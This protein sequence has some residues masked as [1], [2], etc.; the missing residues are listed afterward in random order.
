MTAQYVLSNQQVFDTNGDPLAGAKL[1]FFESGTTTPL[2]TYSESTL[3][4]PNAH[5]VVADSS[6]RFGPIYLAVDEYKVRLDTSADVVIF[7]NDP[8]S[9]LQ[10]FSAGAGLEAHSSGVRVRQLI[11][12]QTGTTYT[13]ANGDRAKLVTHS[14]SSAIAAT[15]P[16]AGVAS[17]FETGWF[18]DVK[19]IGVGAVTIT[20]TTSTID[21]ASS[22]VLGTGSTVRI[23]SDGTNYLTTSGL[24]APV[25]SIIPFSGR[26]APSA[27]LLCYGQAISRTAYASLFAV[28]CPSLGTFTVTIASPAVFT[29]VAH[30]L[31]V[32]ELIRFTTTGALP[33]GLS[34]NTDYFVSNVPS[35]DTFRVSATL[36]GADVNTSGSQSGT[37]TAQFFGYGA[38]DGSTTFTLPDLR[39]RVAAGSDAMGGTSANRLTGVTGSVN[40]ETLGGTG[41]EEAHTLTIA[42]LPAHDHTGSLG[43]AGNDG[44]GT[45]NSATSALT[46]GLGFNQQLQI[47]S[48]GSGTAHNNV[49]PTIILNYIIKV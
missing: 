14:N 38:G 47:A 35:A 20:P 34:A 44:I 9:V 21:G 43:R 19:N 46:N 29:L 36:G 1:Y 4:T 25:G 27:W 3:T 18:A 5:P 42:E 31:Q 39:G 13:Y 40:G 30:G 33:T 7:T 49:Q 28:L 23:I 6:G 16:Q 41:G 45:S 48:Q 8:Y 22:L 37:H 17:A 12:A 15:L 10:E 11:N 2:S 24:S 26:T 32:G